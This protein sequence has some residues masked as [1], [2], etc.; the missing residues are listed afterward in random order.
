[1]YK[2]RLTATVQYNAKTHAV[3]TSTTNPE[4]TID[5]TEPQEANL[6][7]SHQKSGIVLGVKLNVTG[8]FVVIFTG[9]FLASA[10]YVNYPTLHST[11][12]RGWRLSAW[13]LLNH[14][15]DQYEQRRASL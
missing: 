4:N 3:Y 12:Q 9:V 11:R 5:N 7:D 10:E 15:R 6:P 2:D 1:M 14:K 13:T 8:T